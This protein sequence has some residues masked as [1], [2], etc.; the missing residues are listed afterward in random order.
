M[1]EEKA[2][3]AAATLKLGGEDRPFEYVFSVYH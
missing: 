2:K 3:Q 1:A